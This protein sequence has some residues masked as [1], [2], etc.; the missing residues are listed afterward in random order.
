MSVR[1]RL[2]RMGKKK[3][4]FY[5]LVVADSRTQRDGRF[6]DI[7]GTYNPLTQ[8]AEINIDEEKALDWLQKVLS[9]LRQQRDCYL[10]LESLPSTPTRVPKRTSRFLVQLLRRPVP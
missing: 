10:K 3:Q 9:H 5:R 6:I 4:P 2:R 7:I 8:P 1:I